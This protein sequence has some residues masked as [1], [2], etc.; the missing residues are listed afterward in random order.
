MAAPQKDAPTSTVGRQESREL[1]A[2]IESSSSSR[3]PFESVRPRGNMR[4]G[5]PEPTTLLGRIK[6]ILQDPV[7][8]RQFRKSLPSWVDELVA[9]AFVLL[10]L[11]TFTALINPTGSLTG[12]IAYAI[13]VAFGDGAY[14]IAL[15]LASIGGM[16][17]LPRAG[18][19]M[20]FTWTR[21]IAVEVAFMMMQ[22]LL[23]IIIASEEPR[24]FAR[25]GKGGGHVGWAISSLMTD[26]MSPETAITLLGA[27]CVV[28][29][30][31]AIGVQGRDIRALVHLFTE[32][33]QYIANKVQP[34]PTEPADD[35]TLP[36]AGRNLSTQRTLLP[37]RGSTAEPT[38]S[39]ERPTLR[40]EETTNSTLSD[41]D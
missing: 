39:T 11:L 14:L 30:I 10:G 24:A 32:G 34:L 4:S 28:A 19:G 41:N 37:R 20:Q 15:A 36:S 9:F 5:V 23:H 6:H 12:P 26:Y 22:G 18:L 7:A 29:I 1:R 38:T 35:L 31:V 33:L 8:F 17:L 3:P 21:V 40:A 2:P 25:E 16:L 27:V 13:T